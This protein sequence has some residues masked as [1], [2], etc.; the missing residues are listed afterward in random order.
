MFVKTF[1][2]QER[3]KQTQTNPVFTWQTAPICSDF[4][5]HHS[6]RQLHFNQI[7]HD[8]N[9]VTDCIQTQGTAK[10]W[11]SFKCKL[12]S[13]YSTSFM[14]KWWIFDSKTQR[15]GSLSLSSFWEA[16]ARFQRAQPYFLEAI[17]S[18]NNFSSFI[19]HKGNGGMPPEVREA[20]IISF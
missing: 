17:I 15:R 19:Q 1:V 4:T 14:R 9:F 8:C 12:P 5:E 6:S 7:P 13:E 11:Y 18:W 2:F 20:L 16:S 3:V 10:V